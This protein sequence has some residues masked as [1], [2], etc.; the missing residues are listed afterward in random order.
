VPSATRSAHSV[1]STSNLIGRQFAAAGYKPHPRFEV[2]LLQALVVAIDQPG[3]GHVEPAFRAVLSHLATAV[4]A[5]RVMWLVH[6]ANSA[7][8][9]V[10][11]RVMKP[12]GTDGD[13]VVFVVP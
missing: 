6:R 1:A 12:T 7:T 11:R 2:E 5:E 3:R 10:S 13:F 9:E 4:G 8:L